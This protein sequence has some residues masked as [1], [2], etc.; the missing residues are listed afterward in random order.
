MKEYKSVLDDFAFV[1]KFFLLKPQ[2]CLAHFEYGGIEFLLTD[3]EMDSMDGIQLAERL[4]K[5]NSLMRVV[6]VI[7]EENVKNNI[8]LEGAECITRPVTYEKLER[9][10]I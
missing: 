6:F 7:D 4:S 10:M 1:D 5:N 9:F 2:I 3:Y 8:L